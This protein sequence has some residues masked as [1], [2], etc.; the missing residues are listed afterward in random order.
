MRC[1]RSRRGLDPGNNDLQQP[2]L[3]TLRT[4]H[5]VAA[6]NVSCSLIQAYLTETLS[7]NTPWCFFLDFSLH[8]GSL[9]LFFW[10]LVFGLQFGDRGV[11]AA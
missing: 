8:L 2:L 9:K 6:G 5:M 10:T 11:V 3:L 7:R 1:V 4:R